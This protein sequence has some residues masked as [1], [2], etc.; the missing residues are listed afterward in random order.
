MNRRWLVVIALGAVVVSAPARADERPPGPE[1][2]GRFRSA[3][4]ESLGYD[5]FRKMPG[6]QQLDRRDRARRWLRR[7]RD[8]AHESAAAADPAR[9]QQYLRDA[10]DACATAAGLVPYLPDAWLAYARHLQAMGR[11]ADADACLDQFD[12][13]LRYEQREDR[14]REMQ[15]EAHAIAARVAYNRG[16]PE[17]SR[18]EAERALEIDEGDDATR[19]I[20]VRALI[21]L[22]RFDEARAA[23][24]GFADRGPIYPRA[25]AVLG[26][27]EMRDQRY[28]EAERAFDRAWEYGMRGA[29]FDNDRGL[30]YMATD[31]YDRA[32]EHFED[33]IE[34][35]P[36]FHEARN[37]LAVAHR[38]AGRLREADLILQSLLEDQP[39]YAAAHFNRAELLRQRLDA[40]DAEDERRQLA[41]EAML[42]YTAALEY[43]YDPEVAMARRVE[44]AD[45]AG[46]LERAEQD[47]LRMT[48]DPSVDARVLFLLGRI[49]KE[50]GRMDIATNLL[51]MAERRGYDTPRL[52]AEL[53][54][55]LARQGDL[56]G[57]RDELRRAVEADTD[58]SLV[59]TRVN[60]SVV[61][62]QLGDRAA[63]EAVLAEAE[64]LAPDHPL[65]IQQREA[66]S[67]GGE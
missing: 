40:A 14:R 47:L 35:V 12:L 28:G 11:Y 24:D 66:L 2:G 56:E 34:A 25:L 55:V 37:N 3:E 67:G 6:E 48:E 61:L 32:V 33:A 63:A 4:A 52:H 8:R 21:Q 46:D 41:A 51:R 44:I 19:L 64:R 45:L 54:E 5:A 18:T 20:L 10:V 31:R 29:V 59:I 50:Q 42:H 60:L 36:S 1:G 49:K 15:Q 23:V 17:R 39:D 22:E 43:G 62:A 38:R 16:D 26:V 58:G 65:V 7:A 13:T 30:L 53:G 9:R 57:A 27:L